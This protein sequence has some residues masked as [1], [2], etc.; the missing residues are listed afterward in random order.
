MILN[1]AMNPRPEI[2][3]YFTEEGI[4]KDVLDFVPPSTKY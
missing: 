2:Q 4:D 3:N 1:K